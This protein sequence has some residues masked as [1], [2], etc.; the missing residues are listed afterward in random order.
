MFKSKFEGMCSHVLHESR[1]EDLRDKVVDGKMSIEVAQLQVEI[2]LIK[3]QLAYVKAFDFL[4]LLGGKRKRRLWKELQ[5]AEKEY[6]KLVSSG[7]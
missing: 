7:D 2:R 6:E 3:I 5:D 4:G 1:W